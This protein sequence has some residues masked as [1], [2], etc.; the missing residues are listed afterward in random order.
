MSNINNFTQATLK[1]WVAAV[2]AGLQTVAAHS[3]CPNVPFAAK[4]Q[5]T[6]E[7]LAAMTTHLGSQNGPALLASDGNDNGLQSWLLEVD[8]AVSSATGSVVAAPGWMAVNLARLATCR[9][10]CR[11]RRR[12]L[13]LSQAVL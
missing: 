2:V 10:R 1:T 13:A 6:K 3:L 5:A 8:Q 4:R 9:C 11:C 7:I 12:R